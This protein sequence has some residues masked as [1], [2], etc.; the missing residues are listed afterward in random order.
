ML[1]EALIRMLVAEHKRSPIQGK[2]LV[3]GKQTMGI[4]LKKALEIFHEQGCSINPKFDKELVAKNL[5]TFDD[6]Q[7]LQLFNNIEYYSLDIVSEGSS[8]IVHDLNF[9]IPKKLEDQFDFIIDGGTFDHLVD[10]KS[11]FSNVIKMLKPGGRIFQ[12]N[13]ASN[14]ANAGYLSFSADFFHDFYMVNKFAECK[15]FFAEGYTWGA[16]NWHIYEFMPSSGNRYPCFRASP[17]LTMVL[18]LATKGKNSTY[19]QMPIQ[20]Q[21][22][23]SN[24]QPYLPGETIYPT[25]KTFSVTPIK[26]SS[27]KMPLKHKIAHAFYPRKPHAATYRTLG[28]L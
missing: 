17:F 21:Y 3:L 24:P 19:D 15:T 8:S 11:A 12:W 6:T 22:R 4:D 23:G 25:T 14:Y 27:V 26:L 28:W 9:P 5:K 10:I 2:I 1:V 7:F 13:A 20:L 16:Q 18:V